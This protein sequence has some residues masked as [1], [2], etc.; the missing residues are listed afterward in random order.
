LNRGFVAHFPS[1]NK[2]INNLTQPG[3]SIM[4]LFMRHK[5]PSVVV[6]S[7]KAMEEFARLKSVPVVL[8]ARK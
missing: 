2:G 7:S 1:L 8:L 5:Q 4:P 6:R 3:N